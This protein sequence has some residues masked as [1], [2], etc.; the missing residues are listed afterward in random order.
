MK[1][2]WVDQ[3]DTHAISHKHPPSSPSIFCTPPTSTVIVPFLADI[4]YSS[5]ILL[6]KIII[7]KRK[8]EK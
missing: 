6:P 7:I 8:K 5:F 2:K 4:V 1:K 3:L